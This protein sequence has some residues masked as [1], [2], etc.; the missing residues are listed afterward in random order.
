MPAPRMGAPISSGVQVGNRF[1]LGGIV[2]RNLPREAAPNDPRAQVDLM[3][4]RAS[5]VLGAAGLELRHLVSATIYVDNKIPGDAL[6]KIIADVIPSETAVTV[7]RTAALPLDAHIEISGV[8]SRNIRR[9]GN[10]SSIG[11]TLYCRARAGSI[12]IVLGNLKKD[13]DA[14][15]T[16]MDRA[17]QASVFIDHID[18]YAAVNKVYAGAFG[19]MPPARTLVQPDVGAPELSLA[20]TTDAAAPKGNGP[21]VELSVVAVR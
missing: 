18:N 8:A 2:G 4:E 12:D 10:C 16:R 19:T 9:E 21:M 11:E 3:L 13:L 14:A 5:Q 1:Y 6:A 17:V 15:R 7:V 20:P